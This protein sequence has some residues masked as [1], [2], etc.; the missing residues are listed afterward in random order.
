MKKRN[1]SG[2]LALI[3]FAAAASL[4]TGCKATG[5][6]GDLF[7]T[8]F[9]QTIEVAYGGFR[10]L[11][12]TERKLLDIV[13]PVDAEDPDKP[14]EIGEIALSD[15]EY[16][17]GIKIGDFVADKYTVR[18]YDLDLDGDNNPDTPAAE[19]PKWPL[20][21]TR[22]VVTFELDGGSLSGSIPDNNTQIVNAGESVTRPVPDPHKTDYTFEGW[23]G[24]ETLNTVY[25]FTSPVNENIRV[26]AKWAAAGGDGSGTG[27]DTYTANGV[28]F[29]MVPVPGGTGTLGGSP[30][31]LDS[32]D[33]GK[34]EV[35]QGLWEA[36]M[37]AT[38][39]NPDTVPSTLTGV[40]ADYPVYFVSW[41]D[42]V[43]TS[44]GSVGYTINGIAYYT[45]G[46]C[47]QLSQAVGG[48]K[49][50][51]LPTEAEWE[52]AARGGQQTNNY[53]YSGSNTA[54]DVAWSG[55]N[56]GMGLG[57]VAH[58][59]GTKA[60]NE[61][62]IYDMSGNVREWCGDY[63]D[64]STYPSGTNNPTGPA[65]G[66][67]R[68][69][70]NGGF[71]SDFNDCAV[72]YRYHY[73]PHI[74]EAYYGFR[75]ALSDGAAEDGGGQS[76]TVP[77]TNPFEMTYES[78]QNNG[79]GQGLVDT[80]KYEFDTEGQLVA[81]TDIRAHFPSKLGTDQSL[82]G[83]KN[84]PSATFKFHNNASIGLNFWFIPD[85]SNLLA[86]RRTDANGVSLGTDESKWSDTG[87]SGSIPAN[88]DIY[89]TIAP[90]KDVWDNYSNKTFKIY[91]G[92]DDTTFSDAVTADRQV[93]APYK[94]QWELL[95]TT[96]FDPFG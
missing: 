95:G 69:L 56:S 45:N 17:L 53:T 52:Y 48:G 43:G 44:S 47:Y 82:T 37:G 46:F 7:A 51:R 80:Y 70:R 65:T 61:L 88:G 33:I 16:I 74:R 86:T 49:K 68:V 22:R 19:T 84:I 2:F 21:A 76:A 79:T 58:T 14:A 10:A 87:F 12:P 94:F 67:Q 77:A 91:W 93:T 54:N 63:W 92:L 60:A 50:F 85:E 66:P 41:E 4:F 3:G 6:G 90:R 62:G 81:D 35:T 64:S 26:W 34:H 13:M 28:P 29:D 20:D 15:G 18:V 8:L 5:V 72:S 30:V 73:M 36:V 25:D 38:Y 42:I 32:F 40:G 75:L 39:P 83:A 27:D 71:R 11:Q 89:I 55:N 57:M 59:V 23:Y 24:E 31:T 96:G 9:D 78:K 1:K